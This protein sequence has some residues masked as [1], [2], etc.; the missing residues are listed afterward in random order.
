VPYQAA[1]LTVEQQA[2]LKQRFD[3]CENRSQLARDFGID[4]VTVHRYAS[5]IR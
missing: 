5:S 3:A 1:K 4:R 2:E